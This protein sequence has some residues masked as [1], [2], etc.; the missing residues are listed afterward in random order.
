MVVG[1][2]TQPL[3]C[4]SL[5]GHTRCLSVIWPWGGLWTGNVIPMIQFPR[6]WPRGYY[7]ESIRVI[8]LRDPSNRGE[9]FGNTLKMVRRGQ[10]NH[11]GNCLRSCGQEPRTSYRSWGLHGR[12]SLEV[13]VPQP[14][15]INT[16]TANEPRRPWTWAECHPG[17]TLSRGSHLHL[18]YLSCLFTQW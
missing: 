15:R 9:T 16:A 11:V 8:T 7:Q 2:V 6:V 17:L 4:P 12:L 10:W 14:H 13:S 1:R 5:P 18:D 3:Q